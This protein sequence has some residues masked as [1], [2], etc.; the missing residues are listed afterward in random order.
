MYNCAGRGVVMLR[1]VVGWES[2]YRRAGWLQNKTNS[3]CLGIMR[4]V[5]VSK[6][7]IPVNWV[8][9]ASI[10]QCIRKKINKLFV[11]HC[12]VLSGMVPLLSDFNVIV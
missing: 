12:V 7:L 8:R 4:S 5:I 2:H 3:F 9:I 11:L 6:I 10:M 1:W